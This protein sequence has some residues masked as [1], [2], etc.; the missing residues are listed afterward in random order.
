MSK[1][2]KLAVIG[3]GNRYLFA[4]SPYIKKHSNTIELIA[5]SDVIE[6]RLNLVGNLHNI[7]KEHRFLDYKKMLKYIKDKEVDGIFITTSDLDHYIPAIDC[8]KQGYNLLLEKPI[9]PNIKECIDIVNLANKKKL[10]IMVAHV[11]RYTPFFR[12]IKQI[13]NSGIIGEI[14][15]IAHNENILSFHYAHSFVR[16]IWRNSNESSPII[17]SK[18]CHDLDILLYL[19]GDDK[20]CTYVSSFGSLKHFKLDNAPHGSAEICS[21][22][23]PIYKTCPYSVD[24]YYNLMDKKEISYATVVAPEN[25]KEALSK[26]LKNGPYGKCVYYCDNNVCD[27][28]SS[29]IEF[30]DGITATFSLSAFTDDISRTIK[31]MGSH[32]QIRGNT[33]NDTIEV[34]IFGKGKGDYKNKD[35]KIYH[36]LKEE[37]KNNKEISGHD[38]GD[39]R[40]IDEFIETLKG[41]YKSTNSI[42]ISLK[43]HIMAFALEKSRLEH[44]VVKISDFINSIK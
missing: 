12:K 39:D 23:C 3:T 8:L 1:K 29:I 22:E 37:F 42:S 34:A 7:K 36:P 20:E 18:S 31:I 15:S 19:I 44:K 13:I 17:L 43:S 9:S 4:Y 32:G 27:H 2:V 30:N 41:N 25:T 33:E 21:N 28:M 16:G 38:G 24:I 35:I 14:Q 6:D 11:L 5:I 26:K 10:I 40:F